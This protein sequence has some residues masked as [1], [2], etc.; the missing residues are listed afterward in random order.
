MYV[1]VTHAAIVEE[2]GQFGWIISTA[3]VIT[4]DYHSAVIVDGESMTVATVKILLCNVL[5]QLPV[6]GHFSSGNREV[7]LY[8]SVLSSRTM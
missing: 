3:I 4:L 1:L 5:L 7:S 6:S 2:Q 8:L